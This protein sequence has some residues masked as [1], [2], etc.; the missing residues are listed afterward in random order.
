M[1][2]DSI[3]NA[4]CYSGIYERVYRGLCYLRDTDLSALPDGTY[5]L[6]GDALYLS[7]QS[8]T[9]KPENNTPEGHQKYID[10]QYIVSGAEIIAVGALDKMLAE[11]ESRRGGDIRFYTGPV[12]PVVVEAGSF[13]VLWPQD[14]HAPAIA[15]GAPAPVRKALVKV[16]I[17]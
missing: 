13:M 7:L 12:S 5:P 11:D 1:I 6:E 2:F 14:V 15:V 9:T 10:I 4:A 3:Q 8:Y 17:A 16:L